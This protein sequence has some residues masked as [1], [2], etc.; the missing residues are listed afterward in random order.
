[1]IS[2]EIQ[3]MCKQIRSL[4][5]QVFIAEG[6]GHAG[7]AYSMIESLSV[8][9]GKYIREEPKDWFVLSK[10]HAGPAYYAALCCKGKITRE[11]LMTSNQNGTIVPSHPDR[12]R[13]PGVD[14]TTGSLGQGISQAVGLALGLKLQNKEGHVYCIIGD[15]ECNEG[16]VFEA[17]QCAVKHQL[18]NLT[19]LIDDN[20]K[21]VDGYTKDV[22]FQFH[23]HKLM[24]VLGFYAVEINGNSL[25]ECDMA[26]KKCL[27]SKRPNCIIMN[28]LKGHGVKEIE[29]MENC[30]HIHIDEALQKV[31]SKYIERWE[32]EN[33]EKGDA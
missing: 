5:T 7:G 18:Y 15:G 23:F 26:I 10:G 30:H 29:E 3:T 12:N 19:I 9:F 21:Q 24:E 27:Q 31:L 1:M 6:M 17:F 11:Q 22:S 4:T 2:K 32:E 8:L 28:T 16:E 20:K 14:C 33:C 25:E 13:T